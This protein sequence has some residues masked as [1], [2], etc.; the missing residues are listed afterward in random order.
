MLLKMHGFLVIEAADGLEAIEQ[1]LGSEKPDAILL[2]MSLPKV[3]V[4]SRRG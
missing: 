2:D 3:D 4:I 1:L